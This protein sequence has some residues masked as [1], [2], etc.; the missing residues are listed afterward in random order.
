LHIVDATD[1][2]D[3]RDTDAED[4]LPIAR[5]LQYPLAKFPRE[6]VIIHQ[7]ADVTFSRIQR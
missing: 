6:W 5:A 4:R 3:G 7:S 1:H 2:K